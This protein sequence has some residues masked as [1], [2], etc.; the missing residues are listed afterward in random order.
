M[1]VGVSGLADGAALTA[2]EMLVRTAKTRDEKQAL[3][4]LETLHD[5]S[6]KSSFSEAAFQ[7]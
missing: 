4:I 6:E 3:R 1:G 7:T 5:I 2:S